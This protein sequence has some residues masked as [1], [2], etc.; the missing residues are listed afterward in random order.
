MTRNP[1]VVN[2]HGRHKNIVGRGVSIHSRIP[3]L[4]KRLV[5]KPCSRCS[6]NDPP[7]TWLRFAQYNEV[8]WK[9]ETH[10]FL[11]NWWVEIHGDF[12]PM[13]SNPKKKITLPPNQMAQRIPPRRWH[14]KPWRKIPGWSNGPTCSPKATANH[15]FLLE[16]LNITKKHSWPIFHQSN[17]SLKKKIFQS[18]S[19][20]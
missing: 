13:A 18:S 16:Q 17:I 4:S 2:L 8:A 6:T 20:F 14:K 1:E 15:Q 11:P 9:N 19:T 12:H 3:T 5:F 10:I 7:N